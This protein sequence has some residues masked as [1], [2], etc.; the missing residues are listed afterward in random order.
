[1]SRDFGWNITRPLSEMLMWPA[2]PYLYSLYPEKK[3]EREH[4]GECAGVLVGGDILLSL[5]FS[6]VTF[7]LDY[8]I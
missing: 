5:L 7:Y 4:R 2:E 1:M 6:S 3:R 8:T